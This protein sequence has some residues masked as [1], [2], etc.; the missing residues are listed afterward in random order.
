MSS[1]IRS[2]VVLLRFFYFLHLVRHYLS[3]IG[4][5]GSLG[6]NKSKPHGSRCTSDELKRPLEMIIKGVHACS[7]I[8]AM[9]AMGWSTNDWW[10][11]FGQA[12]RHFSMA[13]NVV[14]AT[15]VY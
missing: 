15:D 2:F 6:I 4:I 5:D 12:L 10:G 11:V 9:A 3:Y 8:S 14:S 1:I 13:P 7:K